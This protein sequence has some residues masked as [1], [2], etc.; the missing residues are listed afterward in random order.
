MPVLYSCIEYFEGTDKPYRTL[1]DAEKIDA[2]RIV[3]ERAFENGKYLFLMSHK[4]FDKYD[5]TD[6]QKDAEKQRAIENEKLN[7]SLPKVE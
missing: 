4:E 6:E 3:Y 1:N 2:L 5:K 7:K